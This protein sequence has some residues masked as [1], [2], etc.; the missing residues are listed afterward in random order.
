MTEVS[1]IRALIALSVVCALPA[2]IA[3]EASSAPLPVP[4]FR[5]E[6]NGCGAASVAMVMHY[7]AGYFGAELPPP[8][9]AGEVYRE[10]Y[11]AERKGVRFIDMKRYLEGAGF[12]AFALHGQ[13]RDL[14]QHLAKGRPVIV[15]LSK[16]RLKGMHFAVLSGLDARHAWLNDPTKKRT[17]CLKRGEFEKEWANADHWML[18]AT[19]SPAKQ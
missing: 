2:A 10:L 14:E 4:H 19:P 9:A 13:W 1:T 3:A 15:S 5:Q 16:K 6:K 12:Q 7:W 11:D 17:R 18:L 8:K